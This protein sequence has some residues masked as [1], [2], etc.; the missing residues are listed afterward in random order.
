[1]NDDAVPDT[2]A[3]VDRHP[4]MEDATAAEPYAVA[5]KHAGAN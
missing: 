1:M 4:R 2:H 5:E 3:G